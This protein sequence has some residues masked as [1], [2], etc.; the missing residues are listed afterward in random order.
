MKPAGVFKEDGV[1][2][3]A[4]MMAV[5]WAAHKWWTTLPVVNMTQ[6]MGFMELSDEEEKYEERV[7]VG[8]VELVSPPQRASFSWQ[9]KEFNDGV[10]T[11]EETER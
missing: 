11:R 10:C 3:A 5:R 8:Y 4:A 7:V 9:F 1:P 6:H 2:P